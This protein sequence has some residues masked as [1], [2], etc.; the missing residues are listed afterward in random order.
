MKSAR[1]LAFLS[2]ADRAIMMHILARCE[3]R[4]IGLICIE[5]VRMPS[6]TVAASI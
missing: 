6:N 2:S 4:D 1:Q 3:N 5:H